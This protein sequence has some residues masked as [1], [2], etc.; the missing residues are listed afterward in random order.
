VSCATSRRVPHLFP[1]HG[2][3]EMC[4]HEDCASGL[5]SDDDRLAPGQ[6]CM[7]VVPK[8]F[9]HDMIGVRI[10]LVNLFSDRLP[11]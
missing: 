2:R 10:R 11:L 1:F 7:P 8:L 4:G 6:G 5:D 3:L 9:S